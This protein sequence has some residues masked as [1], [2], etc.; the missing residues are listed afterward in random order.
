MNASDLSSLLS[1]YS[2]MLVRSGG[3]NAA[4]RVGELADAL[5]KREKTTLAQLSKD[6]ALIAERGTSGHGSGLDVLPAIRE[7]RDLSSFI[8]KKG[9]T[10]DL[11]KLMDVLQTLG[12]AQISALGVKPAKPAPAR[13]ASAEAAPL[14]D[15]GLNDYLRRLKAALG[16]ERA[17]MAIYGDLEDKA[18][19]ATSDVVTIADRF[20]GPASPK[21]TRARALKLILSR[22]RKLQ[23]FVTGSASIGR[24]AA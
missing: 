13:K 3:S 4:A 9:A 22:H 8:V 5:A 6:A 7:L 23:D 12:H 1:A 21:T 17:F 20:M 16:D 11:D 24:R 14:S 19:V 2:R 15:D 10:A 18:R